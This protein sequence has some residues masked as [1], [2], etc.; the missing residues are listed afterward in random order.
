MSL[1]NGNNPRREVVN[2]LLPIPDYVLGIGQTPLDLIYNNP[3]STRGVA[4]LTTNSAIPQIPT[5]NAASA[6]IRNSRAIVEESMRASVINNYLT[7]SQLGNLQ[8]SQ[9]SR[10]P[11]ANAQLA[12]AYDR[13]QTARMTACDI[14][15]RN[16]SAINSNIALNASLNMARNVGP[17]EIRNNHQQRQ[18]EIIR[19]AYLAILN[20]RRS[21]I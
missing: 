1:P 7:N 12:A 3:P 18:D 10:E 20:R 9:L 16:R 2:A 13:I 11:I 6:L 19:E 14:Y 8:P 5:V 21:G 15:D 17:L 4:E